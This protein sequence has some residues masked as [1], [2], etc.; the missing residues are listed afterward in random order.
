MDNTDTENQTTT[1]NLVTTGAM[2]GACMCGLVVG[3]I[4]K[5]ELFGGMFDYLP[6]DKEDQDKVN[7]ISLGISIPLIA[8][9]ILFPVTSSITIPAL[10]FNYST[11]FA[12]TKL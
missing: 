1:V 10:G 7:N 2:L 9:T 3:K 5:Q 8:A 4:I 6:L 12:L 11:L